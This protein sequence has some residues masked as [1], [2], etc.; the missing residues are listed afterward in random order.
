MRRFLLVIPI[1][2]S[3]AVL[4]V[5]PRANAQSIYSVAV[6]GPN[7]ITAKSANVV[8]PIGVAVDS[9]NNIYAVSP[10]QNRVFKID[11]LGAITVVAGSGPHGYSGDNGRATNAELYTP[12]GVAVDGSG[13][14]YIA[15][16][17]NE[18]IRVVNT[19]TAPIRVANVTIQPG[20]IATVAGT[21][22]YEYSGDGIPATNAELEYPNG[23][24]VDRSGR[25]Y[26]AD[27]YNQRIRVVDNNG[28][29]STVAGTGT[30]GYGGNGGEATKAELNFPNGVAVDGS[31]K[32]YVA[33]TYNQC[34]RVV[35]NSGII[36]TVAGTGTQGY[37]GDGGPATKA[38][39]DNPV[40]IALDGSG[41]LYIADLDNQRIRVVNTG[42]KAITVANATVQPGD[43]ATVAG[44]GTQGYSGDSGPGTKA[45]LDN[46][47]GVTVDGSGNLY[48][49]DTD[50]QRIRVVNTARN[51][52]AVANITIQAGDMATVAGNGT[53]SYAGD[54]E[55]AVGASLYDPED[56]AIDAMGNVFIADLDNQR[57][58]VVNTGTKAITVANVTI[59]PGNIATVAGTG[60]QG[61]SGDSG[62]AT[63]AELY[64]PVAIALDSSGNLYIA[65]LDSQRIRVVNT[66]TKA[67]TVANATIEPGNITT[68]AG[69]GTQ[70]Y[71]GD[72]GPAT[73]AELD[74][75]NGV[76]VDGAGN[77]Y[78]ADTDNQRIRVVNTGTKPITVANVTVQPGDIATVTGTGR[79]GY[80][81]NS[82]PSTTAELHY[83]IG[84]AVDDSG[85][86]YIADTNNDTIRVVNTGTKAITVAN[87]T[88]QPGNIA[89][90]AGTGSYD[91][92]GDGLAIINEGIPATSAPIYDPAGVAVDSA[93]NIYISDT[94]NQRIRV[95][96]AK[97]II[98]TIAGTG[99]YGNT[100]DNSPAES[101]MLAYPYGIKLDS[102]GNIYFADSGNHRICKIVREK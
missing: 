91:Y 73:K 69:K 60:T 13:N 64:N 25:I 61:Y 56:V 47:N 31:G 102:A 15:D 52:V 75:P 3:L 98:H 94:Y 93:G 2:T 42:T 83:P 37:G 7:H 77:L 63:K 68:V 62:P 6:N 71:S 100:G 101:A 32:I 66:G 12:Q 86:L 55:S 74:N 21:G 39:L 34:I 43:I 11:A 46:P 45:E 41:N 78:I 51:S 26:I 14:I 29:I 49:A 19:Q 89:T 22:A 97:G 35:D 18:R 24:A 81:G 36:S 40:A 4:F 8:Q 50:N 23:V 16:T 88:I 44:T 28:I 48:I 85:N 57:V 95:V 70:G 58:R 1:V 53:L 80:S 38:E 96:N 30:Q 59:Q 17:V 76:I 79:K 33:D 67:T 9:R 72:G 92:N 5:A 54:G 87:T 20:E 84:L 27:T 99:I 90:V 82:G 65:D 10:D